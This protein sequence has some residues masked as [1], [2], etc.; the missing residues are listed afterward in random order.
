MVRAAAAAGP[1]D[2]ALADDAAAAEYAGQVEEISRTVEYMQ[3]LSAGAVDRTRAQAITA[4]ATARTSGRTWIT[5][6][7]NGTA[8]ATTVGDAAWPHGSA[9]PA[10]AGFTTSAEPPAQA[11][12][13]VQSGSSVQGSPD[14]DGCRNAAEFLR[15]RLR[16]SPLVSQRAQGETRGCSDSVAGQRNIREVRRTFSSSSTTA[17][18]SFRGCT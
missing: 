4:A 15:S 14:D 12:R 1:D 3:I 17:S 8:T 2:L 6:W 10:T 5:G 18:T 13:S 7:D 16:I 9:D 11:G